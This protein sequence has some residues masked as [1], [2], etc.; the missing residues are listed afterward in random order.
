MGAGAGYIRL[1]RGTME[2]EAFSREP[3]TQREAWLWLLEHAAWRAGA[4]PAGRVSVR[5]LRG[6]LAAPVRYLSKA[7]QWPTGNVVR[8]LEH[9]ERHEMIRSA[10]DPASRVTVV[11]V[12]NYDAYQGDDGD[13]ERNANRNA[14]CGRKAGVSEEWRN[15]NRNAPGTQIGT[16]IGT[17][18]AAENKAVPADCGTLFGTQSGTKKKEDKKKDSIDHFEQWWAEVPRKVG[19]GQAR[20]TFKAAL[21]KAGSLDV[22]IDGIRR[23]AASVQGK[24]AQYIAHP[25]TWLN[26][27]RWADDLPGSSTGVATTDFDR[28]WAAAQARGPEA[29]D[30]FLAKHRGQAAPERAAE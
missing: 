15:A 1:Y 12:T 16:P 20:Q 28:E 19:K 17:L 10:V 8:F 3:Y 29:I 23:Y 11:T 2:H 4:Q 26:G 30:A 7:W 18:K 6:Q 13:G 27:E 25:T 21:R 9:L 22:L 5:V 14:E 24:D